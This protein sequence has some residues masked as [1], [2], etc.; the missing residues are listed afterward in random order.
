MHKALRIILDVID[1]IVKLFL[2]MPIAYLVVLPI[3]LLYRKL[4]YVFMNKK[5][6]AK[7]EAHHKW[8]KEQGIICELPIRSRFER[9]LDKYIF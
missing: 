5:K 2:V 9:F 1:L 6:R 3:F 7:I 4:S 8:K